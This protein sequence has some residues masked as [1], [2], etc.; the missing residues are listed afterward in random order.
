M[1]VV[2]SPGWLIG[3]FALV[4]VAW[5]SI[6]SMPYAL[7]ASHVAPEKMGIS[8]GI[9]NMFIVIP[10]IVAATLL[11]PLLR[12]AFGNEAIYALLISGVSLWLGALALAAVR[13]PSVDAP[14][15][16]PA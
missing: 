8:M 5:A 14:P 7:L 13:E 16:L 3:S 6:L 1:A 10:Q 2:P 9:F 15:P 12:H 11:G 4:G